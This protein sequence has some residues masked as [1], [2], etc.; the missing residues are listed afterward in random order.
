MEMEQ[1]GAARSFG[2]N[3]RGKRRII[4]IR[5][6]IDGVIVGAME[7]LQIGVVSDRVAD[8]RLVA[9]VRSPSHVGRR[10]RGDGG[11]GG[12]EL[13]AL[14]GGSFAATKLLAALALQG[15]G[16]VAPQPQSSRRRCDHVDRF[17]SIL[18]LLQQMVDGEWRVVLVADQRFDH[19][20]LGVAEVLDLHQQTLVDRFDRCWPLYWCLLCWLPFVV[21]FHPWVLLYLLHRCSFGWIVYEDLIEDVFALRC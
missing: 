21:P 20:L 11:D 3:H 16:R 18:L 13:G 14:G 6:E 10:R 5:D 2:V 15:G 8:L 9:G 17:V 4:V 12:G 1:R 19:A 7:E